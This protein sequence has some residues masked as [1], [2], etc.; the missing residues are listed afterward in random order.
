MQKVTNN[1]LA[2]YFF[3][4]IVKYKKKRFWC[5]R[6]PEELVSAKKNCIA[7]HSKIN[8]LNLL[9]KYNLWTINERWILLFEK[10]LCR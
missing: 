1:L 4:S 6:D 8:Y 3:P 2:M 10:Y 5:N 9:E 7:A